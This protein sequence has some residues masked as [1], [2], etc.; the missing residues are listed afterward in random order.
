MNI[1]CQGKCHFCFVQDLSLET[2]G[3]FREGDC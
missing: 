1:Y 3:D 2:I